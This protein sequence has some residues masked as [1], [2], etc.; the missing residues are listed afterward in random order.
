MWLYATL[1]LLVMVKSFFENMLYTT[2]LNH[3]FTVEVK[4][5]A[6]VTI[7]LKKISS[8]IGV[9]IIHLMIILMLFIYRYIYAEII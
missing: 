7:K 1:R 3:H 6:N 9:K 4:E 5:L 2:H 8:F